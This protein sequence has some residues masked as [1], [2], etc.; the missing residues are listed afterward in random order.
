MQLIKEMQTKQCNPQSAQNK[1]IKNW[2][3]FV[4]LNERVK[5][6][7]TILP[8]ISQLHSKFMQERHWRKLMRITQQTIAFSSPKFCLDDLIKLELYKFSEEVTEL[9][10]GAQKEAKIE[11][12]LNI[13]QKCWDEQVFDFKDY[14]DVP[15]LG[16]LDEIVEFVEQHSM[17]LM[18]MMSSKDVEEF[19][20]RVM[21]WQKTLKTVDSVIQIWV[22]VQRNWQRLEPI[23]LASEDIRA[24]LPDDTR[25]FE[26]IDGAFKEMMREAREEPGVIAACTY[27]GREE[28]LNNFSQEIELCEKALNDYLEQKKKI[29]ARFYFVSNQAL[30]DILSNGNNPEKV[31]EYLGDCFDGM[32]SL[33]FVKGPAIPSP[34]KSAKGMWS[35][36]GEYVL[37]TG[38]FTCNGA[39]ENYLCDLE[40]TMQ[41]TLKDVLEAAKTTADNWDIDKKRHEWLEDYCAQIALLA[42]QVLWTE[43]TTRAF[44]ELEGGSETAMKDY[45]HT[46]RNRIGH[47]IERVRTDLNQDLRVKIITIITIDVHE[48]DVVDNFVLKKIQDQ[49]LFV[50]QSQLKFYMEYKNPKDEKRVCVAKICDWS[51]YYNYE[52]VGNCGR[53][54][55]TPLT[56]RCYITLT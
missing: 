55:I 33:D 23:F 50:W 56:D 11:T 10:D 32:K 9:V 49:Q 53:L 13:I 3:A 22:K 20:E 44:D 39:V 21:H 24:Q 19:K 30:L 31:D 28:L 26:Q 12:K 47:L 41:V 37:F 7:N 27:E 17:E 4:A 43:E 14:K 42:T 6:M 25:R 35:K 36:E 46:I 1:E 54:V 18:G 15:V 48:R 5:N 40:R 8:L 29:F 51:T 45:L 16:S 38:I 52:Y 2:K 34:A